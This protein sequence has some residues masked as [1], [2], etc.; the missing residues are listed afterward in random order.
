MIYIVSINS[1][2]SLK[3][4]IFYLSSSLKNLGL[5]TKI[6]IGPKSIIRLLRL[7]KNNTLVFYNS[8]ILNLILIVMSKFNKFKIVHIFH[9]PQK[10]INELFFYPIKEIFKYLILNIVHFIYFILVDKIVVL[11]KEGLRRVPK[12]FLNKTVESKILLKKN[13]S[14]NNNKT[15]E[16][17]WIGRCSRQKGF[18]KFGEYV[19]K[20]NFKV[21][22]CTSDVIIAEK[23]FE[24]CKNVEIIKFNNDDDGYYA[25]QNSTY[26][27]VFHPVLTQSGVVA[28][29]LSSGCGVITNN[30]TVIN[31]Y[32]KCGF[33]T[34]FKLIKENHV[35]KSQTSEIRK[36]FLKTHDIKM[37]KYYYNFL[38][39]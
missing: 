6:L 1:N 12:I 9:E 7:K 2:I 5:E 27:A 18:F 32:P 15:Y 10:K 23:F 35:F 11:S 28:Q 21:I 33:I 26:A 19:K 37:S 8:S 14:Q 22:I 24:G 17:C 13:F 4:E 3:K 20:N 31:E 38:I 29:A 30:M 36:Q 25:L 34:Y 39:K 16:I